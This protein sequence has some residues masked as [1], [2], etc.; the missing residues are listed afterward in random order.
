M[1]I[2]DCASCPP[3]PNMGDVTY[4]M[5]WSDKDAKPSFSIAT[6]GYDADSTTLL[7]VGRGL[8][9]WGDPFQENMLHILENFASPTPPDR[10]TV[11]QM[12]YDFAN[13]QLFVWDGGRWST[14]SKPYVG[15]I[16]PPEDGLVRGSI[17][18]DTSTR[19]IM[20]Y[21]GRT[22]NPD[23]QVSAG[24]DDYFFDDTAFDSGEVI[25]DPIVAWEEVL[26]VEDAD[27]RYVNAAGDAMTG[28]LTMENGAR[29]V[30]GAV[31]VFNPPVVNTDI[32]NKAAVDAKAAASW[33]WMV[34]AIA[35]LSAELDAIRSD[36][37]SRLDA[38]RELIDVGHDQAAYADL[39]PPADPNVD[40]HPPA[41]ADGRM[42]WDTLVR[43]ALVGKKD[44]LEVNRIYWRHLS[45][46][47]KESL[48]C[49]VVKTIESV[50]APPRSPIGGDITAASAP[51][52]DRELARYWGLKPID[53]TVMVD[54]VQTANYSIWSGPGSQIDV[55]NDINL[56]NYL[57]VYLKRLL[58]DNA[59]T[60]NPYEINKK[61]LIADI[62]VG[63]VQ[64]DVIKRA[65]L[66]AFTRD[67]GFTVFYN[68]CPWG[69]KGPY[70]GY[71]ASW[72]CPSS[73]TRPGYQL[74]LSSL[75]GEYMMAAGLAS[76]P[77]STPSDGRIS[78][79]QSQ[80]KV[81]GDNATQTYTIKVYVADAF[82]G[83]TYGIQWNRPY[84]IVDHNS[85]TLSNE[86]WLQPGTPPAY[87]RAFAHTYAY[88]RYND[89][90]LR[91]ILLFALPRLYHIRWNYDYFNVGDPKYLSTAPYTAGLSFAVDVKN[92]DMST[93]NMSM[94]IRL[95]SGSVGYA[96]FPANMMV[97][98]VSIPV[99]FK[100]YPSMVVAPDGSV[101]AI[102]TPSD[103]MAGCGW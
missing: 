11:G 38:V 61:Y 95:T 81:T 32:S 74:Q 10:Q 45:D 27:A 29:V 49:P 73:T 99:T 102:Y 2:L 28:H 33:D 6:G 23:K 96:Y 52:Q 36:L 59:F 7:L 58:G 77:F 78:I 51:A 65:D 66:S 50:I 101:S 70:P 47:V 89:Y 75:D 16:P 91:N 42:F 103:I 67:V 41:L 14:V 76:L 97:N 30:A 35:A 18:F 90:D 56:F 60:V 88:W 84:G 53:K 34:A 83:K 4:V 17:W 98:A 22:G 85:Q 93:G 13:K 55:Y 79:D 48:M 46:E 72:A 12:W 8:I 44:V 100:I 19:K 86:T 26:T 40:D 31:T 21:T 63:A 57:S 5:D 43:R 25:N 54:L 92:Y 62:N 71:T 94:G 64:S 37:G 69:A 1:S 15:P 87:V 68:G 24:F 80:T 82:T 3:D 39:P 20:Y 9:N